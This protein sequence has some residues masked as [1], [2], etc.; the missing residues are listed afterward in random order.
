MCP[1]KSVK[2]DRVIE[3]IKAGVEKL[4][5]RGLARDV[6]ISPAIITRYV[7]GKVGEP[8]QATLEKIAVHFGKSVAW[9][10][11]GEVGV[12]ERFLEGVKLAEITRDVFNETISD[13]IVFRSE[14]IKKGDID[15]WTYM[16]AGHLPLT[17]KTIT[18]MCAS[19]GINAYWVITGSTPPPQYSGGVV[20]TLKKRTGLDALLRPISNPAVV[21]AKCGQSLRI[22]DGA[23]GFAVLD[24]LPVW[25]CETCCKA[26]SSSDPTK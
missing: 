6:D 7:Q 2:N 19:F 9:L 16:V 25:P 22:N 17:N 24:P 13:A 3:L 4:G 23:A 18:S 11:G 1:K 14:K 8:S 5:V 26:S 15:F 10:R 12:L 20:G 21:C